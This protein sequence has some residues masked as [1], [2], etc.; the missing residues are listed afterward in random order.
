MQNANLYCIRLYYSPV[1]ILYK[2]CAQL[3]AWFSFSKGLKQNYYIQQVQVELELELCSS[4][5]RILCLRFIFTFFSLQSDLLISM[6]FWKHCM[7][8][9][10]CA[11]VGSWLFCIFFFSF[12]YGLTALFNVCACDFLFCYLCFCAYMVE[13]SNKFLLWVYFL[14]FSVH[15]I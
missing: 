7:R 11:C 12:F 6:Y 4:L 15:W 8:M 1:W 9:W 10:V 5:F 3:L 2:S 14:Y 13:F